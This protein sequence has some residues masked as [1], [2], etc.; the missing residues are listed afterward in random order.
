MRPADWL[1]KLAAVKPAYVKPALAAGLAML[2][3]AELCWPGA[4]MPTAREMAALPS[5]GADAGDD[6][7]ISQWGEVIL[8]RPLFT[9]SRRPADQP[10]A[11]T[12]AVLPRLSAIIIIGGTRTAIFAAPGQKPQAVGE[13]GTID[14]YQMQA[15]A[16]DGVKMLGPSGAVTLRPQLVPAAPTDAASGNNSS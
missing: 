9:A 11:S 7:A 10:S 1:A 3:A 14:G 2:L 12:V 4:G 16:P 5:G 6:A 8:A 15:I 13:G